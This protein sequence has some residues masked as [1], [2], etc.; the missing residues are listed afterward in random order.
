MEVEHRPR[1][2]R[3]RERRRYRIGRIRKRENYGGK[4]ETV[5]KTK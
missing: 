3:I 4:G 2:G 5:Y 1:I